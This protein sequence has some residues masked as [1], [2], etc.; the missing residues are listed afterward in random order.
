MSAVARGVLPGCGTLQAPP[1]PT[2][3]Q[4]VK[5]EGAATPPPLDSEGAEGLRG[6]VAP[7]RSCSS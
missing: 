4:S 6:S 7:P 3:A 2:T 1:L 5:W